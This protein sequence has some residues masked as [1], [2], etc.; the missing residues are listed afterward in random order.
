MTTTKATG[1]LAL[2]K[3]GFKVIPG[4]ETDF[5]AYEARVAP[6]AMEHDGFRRTPPWAFNRPI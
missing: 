1:P 2:L 3:S 4:K 6:L 5:L